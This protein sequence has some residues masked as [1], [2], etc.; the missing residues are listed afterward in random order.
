MPCIIGALPRRLPP[1]AAPGPVDLPPPP[2]LLKQQQSRPMRPRITAA[3]A[4]AIA[5]PAS[6]TCARRQVCQ[7]LLVFRGPLPR[8]ALCHPLAAV[9][10][11]AASGDPT[12]GGAAKPQVHASR[13]NLKT[14]RAAR[15]SS[16]GR[17]CARADATR[18]LGRGRSVIARMRARARVP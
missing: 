9:A 10:A 1:Q 18:R 13:Y 4:A 12:G 11:A 16:S 6:A 7:H 5:P 3:P 14:A 2:H 15:S 8:P 17:A